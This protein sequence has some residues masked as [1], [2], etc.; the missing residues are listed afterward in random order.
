MSSGFTGMTKHLPLS[1][2]QR[3]TFFAVGHEKFARVNSQAVVVNP[4]NALN[5][6]WPMPFRKHARVTVSNESNQD[7]ELLAFQITSVPHRSVPR[8]PDT[9]TRNGVGPIRR[10]IIPTSSWT[11]YTGTGVMPGRSCPGRSV[12]KVGLARAK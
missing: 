8:M 11:E 4:A 2:F 3:R 9:F 12:R 1:R 5:C 6:Y 7:L 10:T